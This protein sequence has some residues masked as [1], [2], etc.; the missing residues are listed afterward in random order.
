MYFLSHITQALLLHILNNHP[1]QRFYIGSNTLIVIFRVIMAWHTLQKHNATAKL[2][3]IFQ[4]VRHECAYIPFCHLQYSKVNEQ[5]NVPNFLGNQ[6]N[7][8]KPVCCLHYS[9][10]FS[11]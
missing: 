3:R 10:P 2:M 6:R 8:Y 5:P 7:K 9:S 11:R 4:T 1:I